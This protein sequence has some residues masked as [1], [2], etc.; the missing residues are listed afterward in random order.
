[1]NCKRH[2]LAFIKIPRCYVGTGLEQLNNRVVQ[3]IEPV[4][5][6]PEAMWRVTPNQSTTFRLPVVDHSGRQLEPGK[7]YCTDT[8]PD[9]FLRPF[10]PDSKPSDEEITLD[11]EVLL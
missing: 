11:L 5:G 7:E 8:L 4:Y 9:S 3:T 10:N 2:Q 1:M 6:Y